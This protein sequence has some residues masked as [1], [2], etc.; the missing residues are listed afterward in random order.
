MG[1][2]I[3]QFPSYPIMLALYVIWPVFAI[4]IAWNPQIKVLRLISEDDEQ[5]KIQ[6]I[7]A[8]GRTLPILIISFVG[9]GLLARMQEAEAPLSSPSTSTAPAP[10][11]APSSPP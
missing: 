4:L 8:Y 1:F 7:R 5:A 11:S 3:A 6:T 9:S 10:S 2:F